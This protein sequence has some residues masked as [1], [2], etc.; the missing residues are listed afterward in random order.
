[1]NALPH[2]DATYRND[3]ATAAKQGRQLETW[4]WLET[5]LRGQGARPATTKKRTKAAFPSREEG[6]SKCTRGFGIVNK[7]DSG[8]R[9]RWWWSETSP[10]LRLFPFSRREHIM[11]PVGRGI[12]QET[13][14]RVR[15]T[16]HNIQVCTSYM[17]IFLVFTALAATQLFSV[18]SKSPRYIQNGPGPGGAWGREHPR[19]PSPDTETR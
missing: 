14:G 16:P 6:M 2:C 3:E 13:G 15:K 7:S 17:Y 11:N 10:G 19:G 9:K 12:N 4:S 8:E 1:M 5:Q 18:T